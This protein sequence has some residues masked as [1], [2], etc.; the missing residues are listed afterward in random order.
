M[1]IVIMGCGRV[2]AHL[3]NTMHRDHTITIIDQSAGAFE[4]LSPEFS[5][6]TVIGPGDDPDVLVQAGIRQA[7]AF[8]ALTNRD[9]ANIMGSQ[10]AR[11]LFNVPRVITRIYDHQREGIYHTLGL[12]TICP[13]EEGVRLFEEILTT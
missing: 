6:R 1:R 12:E 9:N 10:M 8:A 2:G 11:E 13:T 5:G 7:D 4:R 3:A